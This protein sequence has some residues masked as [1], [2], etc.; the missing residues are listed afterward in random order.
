VQYLTSRGDWNWMRLSVLISYLRANGVITHFDRRN[1][2]FANGMLA[3][4]T[5]LAAPAS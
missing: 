3:T 5:A 1:S 4:I 2:I